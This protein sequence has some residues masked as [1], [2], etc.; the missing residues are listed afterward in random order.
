MSPWFT[1]YRTSSPRAYTKAINQA[2]STY[3]L[4]LYLGNFGGCGTGYEQMENG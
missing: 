4:S 2:K 1:T 3:E